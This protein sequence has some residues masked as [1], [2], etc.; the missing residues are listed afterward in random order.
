MSTPSEVCPHHVRFEVMHMWWENLT[1]IHFGIDPERVQAV[2]PPGLTVDTLDGA[3]WVGLIPF[4]MRVGTPGAHQ[5]PV[6][7]RFA[8]TN[9][10]TYVTGP[11]GTPGVWFSSLEASNLVATYTARLTYGLPYF[12]SAMSI[13]Q[14]ADEVA[15]R[16]IRRRPGPPGARHH[17]VVR[18]GDLI[19]PSAITDTEHF[20]TGRWGLYS[21]WRGR[22]VYA[23]IQHDPWPL[24]RATVLELDD[25][26]MR[27]A[28]LEPE[29]DRSPLVHWTPG[30]SIRIGRPSFAR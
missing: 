19:E 6:F 5:L 30:T 13:E 7:G 17:S 4:S 27:A 28:D 16:S 12:W 20:L 23:P 26:L 21:Q 10:R 9:V 1:F 24:H 22:L 25:E 8:E 18:I 11:D 2:L 14:R 3:T 29:P 15:Y